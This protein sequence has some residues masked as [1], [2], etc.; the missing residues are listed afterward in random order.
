MSVSVLVVTDS[1]GSDL[2]GALQPV[3]IGSPCN[4]KVAFLPGANL[5]K[6]AVETI[7]E[8]RRNYYSRIIIFGGICSFTDKVDTQEEKR[9]YYPLATSEAKKNRALETIKDLYRRFG[10]R[11]NVCTVPP[12]SLTKYYRVKNHTDSLPEGIEEEEKKLLE[13]IEALNDEIRTINQEAGVTTLNTSSRVYKHSLK[14]YKNKA[15]TRRVSKFSDENLPDGLHFNR[16]LKERINS[17][18]VD[19]ICQDLEADRD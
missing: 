15:T 18:V 8:E 17:I 14:R 9:L 2:R 13:D 6:I 10:D 19:I 7:Q 3:K 12:A 4:I 5:E 1:R 16:Q 11:I